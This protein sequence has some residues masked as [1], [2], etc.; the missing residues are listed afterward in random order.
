MNKDT[1]IDEAIVSSSSTHISTTEY[2]NIRVKSMPEDIQDLCNKAHQN[3]NKLIAWEHFEI[4]ENENGKMPLKNPLNA[5]YS[6]DEHGKDNINNEVNGILR[7]EQLGT[8][9][10]M[11]PETEILEYMTRGRPQI[12]GTNTPWAFDPGVISH[13]GMSQAGMVNAWRYVADKLWFND[14]ELNKEEYLRYLEENPFPEDYRLLDAGTFM[15]V[16][17]SNARKKWGQRT[18]GLMSVNAIALPS[19]EFTEIIDK[20]NSVTDG[21]I[22]KKFALSNNIDTSQFTPKHQAVHYLLGRIKI[23]I[24]EAIRDL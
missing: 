4:F 7:L 22:Y 14:G 5:I 8:F 2:G 17:G 10:R 3:L 12:P 1:F 23:Q 11:N 13:W 20:Q 9:V 18:S 16:N 19:S 15:L 24:Q 6:Q 21:T